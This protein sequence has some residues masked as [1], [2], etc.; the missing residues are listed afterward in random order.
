MTVSNT[1]TSVIPT[2]YA[3]ALSALR[4]NLVMP[5]LVTNDFGTEVA[6]KGQ[7]IQIPLPSLMTTTAVVPAAYAPDPQNIAPT[8]AQIPLNSW[9]ESAFTLSEK[10][11]AQIIAGIAPMQMTAAVQALAFQINAS[12]FLN[13]QQVPNLVGTPG[14]TPFASS[15]AVVMSAATQ[16]TNQLAPMSQRSVVLAPNAWGNAVILPQFAY[17]LYAGDTDAVRHGVIKQK[18]GFD[19]A[20]DQQVPTQTAGALTGTVT[21]SGAQAA[22]VTSVTIAT[23]GSSSFSPTVGDIIAFSG[24]AQ[25]YAVQSGTALGA[26]TSGAFVIT[27]AKVVALAGGETVTLAASHVVNLAFHKQAF[28]FASRPLENDRLGGHDPDMSM[29]VPDP[30]SGINMRLIVREEYHRTRVAFDVL[31]GTAPIRPLLASRIA[32]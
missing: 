22:G 10:E 31:W 29:M 25:Q 27:P 5:G 15:P 8:T 4:S 11:V 16:M 13:Y 9:Y 21:A 2:L 12:I 7:I 26:S 28:G 14:T 6:Q 3:Q 18:F 30:V 17:A 24:D 20:Q 23:A 32:G 19:W 1:L